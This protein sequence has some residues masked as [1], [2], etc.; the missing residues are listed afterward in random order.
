MF[1]GPDADTLF[2]AAEAGAIYR[3]LDSG[4]TWQKVLTGYIGSF[5]GGL[6]AKDGTV[7]ATGMRGNIWQLDRQGRDL[8]QSSTPMAPINRS[9]PAS[10]STTAASSSSA[11]RS[12]SLFRR[13]ARSSR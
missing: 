11:W 4:V 7:Y 5:W 8:G 13:T 6:T 1:A 9:P 2:V 3:S 10:S 12:G